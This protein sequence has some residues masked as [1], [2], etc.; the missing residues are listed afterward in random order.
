MNILDEII[1][2]KKKEVE[3]LKT[4]RPVSLLE[5]SEYF[6][7]PCLSMKAS[8]KDEDRTGI[9]A[10]FKRQS[11]SKG[12]INATSLVET[13]TSGYAAAGASVLSVLTDQKYFG[14]NSNDLLAARKVNDIP[15]LRKDFMVDEYQVIEAKAMGADV[16]LLL[17][18]VL[19]Y[20]ELKELATTAKFLGMEI[21]LEVRDKEELDSINILIDCVGVNNR[22]LKDFK[23]D[24]KQSFDLV[25]LIPKGIMKISE[26]GID[27]AKT[28]YDLKQAGFNGFLI[29]EAFMK[30]AQPELAF[31]QFVK[32]MN[33]YRP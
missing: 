24:I 33:S 5:K 4:D 6:N 1:A 19:T 7:R 20:R 26:S 30:N 22:N 27:S 16:I 15:I 11:P 29:G 31:A 18:N 13:V 10:E 28:I 9:I 21:L 12:I 3:R 32:E 8:L 17:A 25:N 2:N 14:G 23:V